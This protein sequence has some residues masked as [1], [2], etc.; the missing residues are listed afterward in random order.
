MQA[1]IK[2]PGIITSTMPIK[3]RIDTLTSGIRT[4]VG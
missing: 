2:V 4:P 1:A 3:G